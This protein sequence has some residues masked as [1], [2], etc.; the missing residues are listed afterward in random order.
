MCVALI[1]NREKKKRGL[2][3]QVV[4]DKHLTIFIPIVFFFSCRFHLLRLMFVTQQN[5]SARRIHVSQSI[6]F[7][8]NC[9]CGHFNCPLHNDGLSGQ[10]HFGQHTIYNIDT[11]HS[12]NRNAQM[13]CAL[14]PMWIGEICGPFTIIP[15]YTDDLCYDTHTHALTVHMYIHGLLAQ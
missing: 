1:A 12:L 10:C 8:L 14:S 11:R 2:W 9:G 6:I 15:F 4:R 7:T 13:E 5:S 3:T